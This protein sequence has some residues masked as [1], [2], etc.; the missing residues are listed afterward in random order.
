M[1]NNVFHYWG[2][3]GMIVI[4]FLF[5]FLNC[6]STA[7]PQSITSATNTLT[8]RRTLLNAMRDLGKVVLVYHQQNKE[9]AEAYAELLTDVKLSSRIPVEIEV[10]ADTILTETFIKENAVVLIGDFEQHLVFEQLL[11]KLPFKK[12]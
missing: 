1:Q 10:Q 5:L 12:G 7:E 4:F 2:K 3:Q 8:S 9:I 11:Q 6:T